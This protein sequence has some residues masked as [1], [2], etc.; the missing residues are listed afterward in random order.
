MPGFVIK[1]KA[2]HCVRIGMFTRKLGGIQMRECQPNANDGIG[3]ERRAS[4]GHEPKEAGT[5][6]VVRERVRAMRT[7]GVLIAF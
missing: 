5:S 4:E 1:V 3:G 2:Q 6:E 7:G